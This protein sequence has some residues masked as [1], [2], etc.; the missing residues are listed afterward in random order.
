MK[1]TLIVWT[2]AFIGLVI[3]GSVLSLKGIL[4]DEDNQSAD[5]YNKIIKAPVIEDTFSVADNSLISKVKSATYIID[6]QTVILNDGVSESG[7]IV[8]GVSQP[9]TRFFGNEAQGDLDG[10][11]QADIVFLITQDNGGSGTFFYLAGAL[12]VDDSY[13][14]LNTIFLGDRI[15]PQTTEIKKG[16]I[17]VN[18]ADRRA[19]EPMSSTP[20]V[21]VSK[22]FQVVG[23]Q[24]VPTDASALEAD[25]IQMANPA[26]TN[27]LKLGGNLV[28]KERGDGGQYSLCYFDDARACEEWALM[29]G[30]CPVGGVKTTGFDT[31]DQKYCAWVGGRT[32]AETDSV[33]TFKDGSKCSTVD[34]FNGVCPN[35]KI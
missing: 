26:A 2:V 28:T 3:I 10:D 34:F 33:C 18:Y 12:A 7:L 30:D 9:T 13:Q 32:I 35:T 4:K 29:R 14:I 19:D 22:Y 15:S 24:L 6:N 1:K 20:S 16:I 23:S 17:I 5:D 27:C 8:D 31:I 21:G 25:P 11:G